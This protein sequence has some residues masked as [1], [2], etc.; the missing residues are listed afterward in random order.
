[1]FSGQT[2][3]V[4][5]VSF[6]GK[7]GTTTEGEQAYIDVTS[8]NVGDFAD[9]T[10]MKLA[11]VSL[12]GG[13]S[14]DKSTI[15]LGYFG[16]TYISTAHTFTGPTTF[17]NAVTLTGG[18]AS[19]LPVASGGTGQTSYTDGQLLIGNTTGST[20]TKATLTAGTGISITNGTGSITIAS[21]VSGT[22]TSVT[23]TSPVASSG[24]ATPAISLAAGYGD[25]LNPYASKTANTFLAAPNGA[26]GVPGFRALVA[27]DLSDTLTVAKGGTGLTTYTANGVLYAS[28]TGTLANGSSLVFTGTNLGV[29][30][31]APAAILSVTKT[32]TFVE[33]GLILR[34]AN[35]TLGAGIG[36]QFEVGTGTSGAT[37][38]RVA[39]IE[40]VRLGT[41]PL[42]AIDFYTKSSGGFSATAN[43]RLDDSGDLGI[44]TI[45]PQSKLHVAAADTDSVGRF[46]TSFSSDMYVFLG[47][48]T[49][50]NG[51]L[52]YRGAAMTFGV[53]NAE[54]ARLD[55]G[56]NLQMLTGAV[57]PYAPAPEVLTTNGTLTNANLQAQIINTTGSMTSVAMPTGATLDTLVTSWA[58]VN[59][60][61]DF[62]VINTA[63]GTVTFSASTGVTTLGSLAVATG[64]SAHFRIRRTAASTYVLYRLS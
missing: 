52:A 35:N 58:A 13:I 10:I 38:S 60:S 53:A 34:N 31:N 61:Y 62:Y 11:S 29:G 3:Q 42:G 17:S 30:T 23:G 47:N 4:G 7:W 45:N 5:R 18:L 48:T 56:G 57:M 8:Q 1:V 25:T 27:A 49:D 40:G 55:V 51:Y 50:S 44:G 16:S 32:S 36:I 12:L 24:G 19:A 37:T 54:R 28:G 6:K 63:S 41:G 26:A 22:V 2:N 14:T 21:T 59:V 39:Q 15:S 20:L 64:T 33:T 46:S 9:T 43:M